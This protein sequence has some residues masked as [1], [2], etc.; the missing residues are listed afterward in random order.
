VRL[1]GHWPF[2]VFLPNFAQLV[3]QQNLPK[4]R[5]VA[6]QAVQVV[7]RHHKQPNSNAGVAV[8]VGF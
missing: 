6:Q 2:L 8:V 3:G 5:P 4:Q 1:F 7:E